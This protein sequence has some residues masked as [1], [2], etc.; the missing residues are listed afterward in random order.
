MRCL[1]LALA[2]FTF[3]CSGASGVDVQAETRGDDTTD[4]APA[5]VT[6]DDAVAPTPVVDGGAAPDVLTAPD[7]A[8][9]VEP[10]DD[11][12]TDTGAP[13]VVDA[14]PTPDAGD[15]GPS[16]ECRAMGVNAAPDSGCPPYVCHTVTSAV[17]GSLYTGTTVAPDYWEC[18]PDR[19]MVGY[20]YCCS[21]NWPAEY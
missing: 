5:V 4:A 18:A 1:V 16:A 14:A 21:Y 15:P 20:E 2:L 3:A 17:A 8:L 19:A 9:V 6:H 12:G 13:P 10:T 11:A 7:A